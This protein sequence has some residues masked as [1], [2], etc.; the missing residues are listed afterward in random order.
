MLMIVALKR[1]PGAQ[2]FRFGDDAELNAEILSL[3]RAGKK[4]V[5][6]DAVEA[7]VTRGEDLPVPGRID[8]AC[9]WDWRPA[10]AVETVTLE[11]RAFEEMD[12][13]LVADQ[14]EFSDLE[15][16]RQGYR[17]YL[18]R[19]VGFR[20]GIEMAVERFRLVEDLG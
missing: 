11:R 15:E 5:T 6:C 1:Y 18:E 9:D 7:F 10:C 12:E 20:P 8:I 14:G 4:T 13:V 17:A 2:A 19:S 3:V 16:W